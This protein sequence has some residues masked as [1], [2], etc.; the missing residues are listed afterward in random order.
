MFN[1][2]HKIKDLFILLGTNKWLSY[3]RQ[4]CCSSCGTRGTK[5][6]KRWES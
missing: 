2:I 1:T 4:L 3:S 5:E 6:W